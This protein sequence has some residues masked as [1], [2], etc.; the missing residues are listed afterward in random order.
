MS[1]VGPAHTRISEIVFGRITDI[2]C[3]VCVKFL[4][5]QLDEYK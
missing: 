2:S 5:L 1:P 4:I 3:F